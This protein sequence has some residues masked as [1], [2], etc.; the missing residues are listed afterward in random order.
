MFPTVLAAMGFEIDG[1]RLG[2][3]TNLFSDRPTLI[4][5]MRYESFDHELSMYSAYYVDR[6][7]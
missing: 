2:L 1:N 5:E 3:G 6:F 4:E 7:Q